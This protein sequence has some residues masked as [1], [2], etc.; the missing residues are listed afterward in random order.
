MAS[1]YVQVF[2]SAQTPATRRGFHDISV[3][4]QSWNGSVITRLWHKD[5]TLMVDIQTSDTSSA[6]GYTLFCGSFDEFKRR[7]SKEG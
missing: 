1:F 7:L 6:S 2:G 4:A 3:S 5:D